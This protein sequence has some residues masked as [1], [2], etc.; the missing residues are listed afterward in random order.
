[1]ED[2]V[3]KVCPLSLRHYNFNLLYNSSILPI[4]IYN[5]RLCFI[6]M[7]KNWE[8]GINWELQFE[9]QCSDWSLEI[10]TC[11]H[12]RLLL[13]LPILLHRSRRCTPVTAPESGPCNT[14]PTHTHTH[15][16][17]SYRFITRLL[18]FLFRSF[19]VTWS[20]PLISPSLC[21]VASLWLLFLS[22]DPGPA[23]T[24]F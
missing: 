4:F 9:P 20:K 15:P 17:M 5:S 1:M 11:S 2:K 18:L 8:N 12:Y 10:R 22:S 21:W 7:L 23:Q 6:C 24:W 13:T 16:S 3:F 14:P 19:P